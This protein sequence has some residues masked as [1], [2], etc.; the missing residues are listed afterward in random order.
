MKKPKLLNVNVRFKSNLFLVSL[1]CVLHLCPISNQT[2][3]VSE[4]NES[5]IRNKKYHKSEWSEIILH[6]RTVSRLFFIFII[7]F[8]FIMEIIH[9]VLRKCNTRKQFCFTCHN[10]LDILFT[11]PAMLLRL[12]YWKTSETPN[13]IFSL[14][15]E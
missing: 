13:A 7:L 4:D 9:L 14:P 15:H 2:F 8:S 3:Y 5:F 1:E 12:I 6:K 10:K 11:S